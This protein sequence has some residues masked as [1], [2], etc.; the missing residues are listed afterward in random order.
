MSYSRA[1]INRAI[2]V[3]AQGKDAQAF[4]VAAEYV[5]EFVGL[6]TAAGEEKGEA[7]EGLTEDEINTYCDH[8]RECVRA[9]GENVDETKVADRVRAALRREI[10]S[11]LE[12][13]NLPYYVMKGLEEVFQKA[14]K[15][16]EDYFQKT[17]IVSQS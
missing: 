6:A 5:A 12:G 4:H 15:G 8:V 17:S 14:L 9:S 16:D 3:E 2:Q 7:L 1:I 11:A 10:I 13:A